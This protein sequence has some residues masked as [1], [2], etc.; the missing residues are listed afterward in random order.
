MAVKIAL[1]NNQGG[2]VRLPFYAKVA[3]V[4]S[5]SASSVEALVI[6]WE[7]R[8]VADA[9]KW[10]APRVISYESWART[11]ATPNASD[12]RRLVSAYPNV[13]WAEV[14]AAER[15]FTDYSFLLGSA[16]D[17]RESLQYVTE[18]LHRIVSFFEYLF[19][20]EGVNS[21]ACPTADTLFTLVGFKVAAHHGVKILS[22]SAAWLMPREMTGAGMLTSDEFMTCPRMRYEYRRLSERALSEDEFAIADEM[23]QS[24]LGFGGKTNFSERS[25]GKKAGFS[26]LSPNVLRALEY[27][28]ENKRLDKRINYTRFDPFEKVRANVLRVIRKSLA[29]NWFGTADLGAVPERSVFFALQYQPEQSTLTQAA[30]YANQVYVIESISRSLPPGYTLIVK[31]HPWGRGNRPVWQYKHIQRFYNV[32]MCDAPAKD[33]IRKVQAVVALSGT[34]AVE[35]LVMDRPTVL[36]GRAFFD[37]SALFYKPTCIQELP[38][39]LRAILIDGAYEDRGDRRVEIAR[40]LLAYRAGLIPAFPL[41]ENAHI[42]ASEFLREL[43][44]RRVS[45]RFAA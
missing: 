10:G 12:T 28:A 33:I 42:Y 27:L 21:I 34:V 36:L 39:I 23:A 14:I 26:A 17:R 32:R 3:D 8:E 45:S 9:Q 38:S 5:S 20:E 30:W 31:E 43:E 16:G 24:V 7:D 13:N 6:V 19:I 35:A 44:F 2:K 11:Q 37:Y 41:P 22:E 15:S 1:F 18:L 4:L 40:F 25:K 29:K